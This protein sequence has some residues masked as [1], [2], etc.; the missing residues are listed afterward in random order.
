MG[1]H[2]C[3]QCPNVCINAQWKKKNT[4][5]DKHFC[6]TKPI[7]NK[8]SYW[9]AS[10]FPFI[11]CFWTEKIKTEAV[12]RFVAPLI[13]PLRERRG[14]NFPQSR[15]KSKGLRWNRC[16][17]RFVVT[18]STSLC[19]SAEKSPFM[20]FLTLLPDLYTLHCHSVFV[21]WNNKKP[22]TQELSAHQSDA[23][24]NQFSMNTHWCVLTYHRCWSCVS[25]GCSPL[26]GC[27][28]VLNWTYGGWNVSNPVPALINYY[29]LS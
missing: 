25:R 16:N 3:D 13:F 24:K 9:F 1:G 10:S 27:S 12:Y 29:F 19:L 28:P 8:H 26:C 22:H 5:Q 17:K 4:W 7:I 14:F 21:G 23:K 2:V 20:Y 15:S 18:W 6:L 11:K